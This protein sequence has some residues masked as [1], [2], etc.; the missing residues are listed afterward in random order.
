MQ[1]VCHHTEVHPGDERLQSPI[2]AECLYNSALTQIP[3]WHSECQR[4]FEG[5]GFLQSHLP[6]TL[7]PQLDG[8]LRR[9]GTSRQRS[10]S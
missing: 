10:F 2:S 4:G 5:G 3:G 8:T 7:A 1:C 9:P 6:I